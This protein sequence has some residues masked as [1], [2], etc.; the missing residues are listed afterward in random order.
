VASLPMNIVTV[1]QQRLLVVSRWVTNSDE[2]DDCWL[3]LL[4]VFGMSPPV[5]SEDLKEDCEA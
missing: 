4:T 1:C 3:E 2:S 5:P